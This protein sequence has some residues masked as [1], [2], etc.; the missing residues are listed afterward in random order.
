MCR[1]QV[2]RKIQGQHRVDDVIR[3]KVQTVINT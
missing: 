3:V 1:V 2:D